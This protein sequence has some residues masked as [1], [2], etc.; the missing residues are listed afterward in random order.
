MYIV[1]PA[2]GHDQNKITGASCVYK[3]IDNSFGIREIIRVFT[4]VSKICHQFFRRESLIRLDLIKKRGPADADK[5]GP[6]K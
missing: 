4:L 5:I 6:V 2:V 1:K 3:K